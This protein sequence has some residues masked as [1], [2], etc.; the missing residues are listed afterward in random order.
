MHSAAYL[1]WLSHRRRAPR[2]H[3]FRYPLFMAWLDLAELDQ[4]FRGRWLWSAHRMAVARFRREDHLGDPALPLE[5]AVRDLVETR[6]GR[7]PAGPIRLLTHLRYLGYVFNPV[8]FYYC[9]DAAGERVETVVAEVNNTPWGERHCYVVSTKDRSRKAM[10]VSPFLPMDL[11]YLWRFSPP[12][13][14]LAVHM[15]LEREGTRLFDATL[16]LRR[17]KLGNGLLLRFPLMTLQV[18]AAIHWEAL[19]LWLKRVPVVTHPAK[20]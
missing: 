13:E 9:F 20:A 14:R 17:T 4:V 1:G 5:R 6:T 16:S 8:S 3:A 2:P 11:D 12:G 10:H 15:A 19:R 7:R 18:I